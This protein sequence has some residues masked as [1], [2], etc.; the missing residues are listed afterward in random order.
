MATNALSKVFVMTAFAVLL[1][2]AVASSPRSPAIP[3]KMNGI[4]PVN[5]GACAITR[6]SEISTRLVD[7]NT[8]APTPGSGSAVSFRNGGY[9][10]SYDE[11]SEINH[12]QVGDRVRICL[13]TLPYPCPPNDHRGYRY[14]TT[15]LRTNEAWT[16]PDSPHMCGGA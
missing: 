2:I 7:S 4:L 5:I 13:V 12:S 15:N 11:V 1:Y 14:T 6:I 16:L 10:V 8:G 9:Q 3:S